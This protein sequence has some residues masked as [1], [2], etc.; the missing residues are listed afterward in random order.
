MICSSNAL[1]Y[2]EFGKISNIFLKNGYPKWYITR[3]REKFVQEMD[4]AKKNLDDIGEKSNEW[5]NILTLP[6]IGKETVRLGRRLKKSFMEAVSVDLQIVYKNCKVGECFSLKDQTP[7][8]FAPNV[9]Y[10]FQCSVD[11]GTSYIGVTTR[12]LCARI[13]E[14]LSPKQQSAVQAHLAECSDCCNVTNISSLFTI[15][16]RCRNEREAQAM[17]VMLI[18]KL[19]PSLNIQMGKHRG[20]SF[21]LKVFK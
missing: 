14:H 3:E 6:Y 20:Q 1:L 18:T 11:G 19:N 2:K 5:K 4:E 12:Q 8:L 16:K 9:V 7:P 17:E 13:V 15:L 21:L 10:R